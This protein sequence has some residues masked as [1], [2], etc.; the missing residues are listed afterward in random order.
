MTGRPPSVRRELFRW[1]VSIARAN[2]DRFRTNQAICFALFDRVRDPTTDA[3]DRERRR[4]ER[5]VQAESVEEER[6]IKLDVGLQP[7]PGLVLLEQ[8]KRGRLDL[9]RE[10]VEMHV[11]GAGEQSFS[12]DG[13]N[14]GARITHFVHAVTET[15]QPITGLDFR[16][17][18]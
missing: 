12:G 14:I 6:R 5:N 9:A 7:P 16:A 15:H 13:E 4:K 2:V 11:A 18:H 17:K 8:A 10:R 1:P 3:R